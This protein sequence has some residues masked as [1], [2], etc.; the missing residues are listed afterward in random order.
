MRAH[1]Y[2]AARQEPK[3][4]DVFDTGIYVCTPWGRFETAKEIQICAH[5]GAHVGGHTLGHEVPVFRKAGIR[6]ASVGI[7]S[8]FFGHHAV[9]AAKNG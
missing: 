5:M 6:L 9:R 8:K 7:V 3:F 4:P 2:E 1:L